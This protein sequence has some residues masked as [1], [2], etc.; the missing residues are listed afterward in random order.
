MEKIAIIVQARMSSSRLPG[1][2]MMPLLG[3]SLLARMVERLQMIRHKAMI[4]I[5]TTVNSEDDIIE[6]EA[7][8]LNIPC[9]RGSVNNL[10]ERH[11][12][13]AIKYNADVV[14]KIPS[15]C[16]LI[17]PRI[18]DEALAF[19]FEKQDEYDYMSNLHPASWPDGNDVEIMTIPCLEK[20]WRLAERPLELE[21][22]TPFIW[23]N[24]LQFR[25]GNVSWSRGLDYSM[26]HR[27]TIDYK[28]D[29][30]FIT[31]VYEEL[32]TNNPGFS[33]DDILK[34]L[35]EKPEIRELNAAYAGVNWYRH[36]LDEL[37]TI[38]SHQTKITADK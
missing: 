10:L 36:H 32:Y 26:S 16:P 18:I 35:I 38:S 1:K 33:C 15:D 3:K 8:L 20:T 34:L 11:Y 29:Y 9:Y 25:I 21:H 22:T 24:P 4:I 13:A 17:D 23:E 31:R 14:L 6:Q 2:V 27:F 19:F 7:T 12:M 5:A 37:H 28:E 30:D